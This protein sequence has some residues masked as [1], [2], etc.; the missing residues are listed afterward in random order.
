MTG[1]TT[2]KIDI[3]TTHLPNQ[4]ESVSCSLSTYRQ[5]VSRQH[6][7]LHWL[8]AP[9]NEWNKRQKQQTIVRRPSTA[10]HIR[11]RES[12]VN[13]VFT[14]NA[15]AICVAPSVP[16]LLSV[17]FR[18]KQANLVKKFGNKNETAFTHTKTKSLLMNCWIS[19]LQQYTKHQ[20]HQFHSLVTNKNDF[21]KKQ[22]KIQKIAS[23]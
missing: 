15:F 13:V 17:Y 3:N 2:D 19:I 23:Q 6:R 5:D 11:P 1:K 10:I 4:V 14:F 21:P 8:I 20:H 9:R 7:Q 18:V 12:T 22:T 16:M